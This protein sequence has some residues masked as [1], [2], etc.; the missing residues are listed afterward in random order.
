M[1]EQIKAYLEAC[2]VTYRMLLIGE[3]TKD[4]W[5]CDKWNVVLFKGSY[6]VMFDYYTGLGHRKNLQP[7]KPEI[8]G[9]IC[10][11]VLDSQALDQSFDDWCDDLGFNSDSRKAHNTYEACRENHYKFAEIFSKD[12]RAH[13]DKLLEE[14]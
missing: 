7:V 1:E 6:S 4:E 14:Y 2:G 12:E 13:M 8:A 11:L 5:Q 10:S 3:I 9:V